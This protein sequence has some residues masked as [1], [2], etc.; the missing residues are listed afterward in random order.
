MARWKTLMSGAG[1]LAVVLCF[2]SLARADDT[3]SGAEKTATIAPVFAAPLPEGVATAR[4]TC[5]RG[6][7]VSA[8]Y[9]NSVEPQLAVI[10]VE[11]QQVV[12]QSGPTG[13][14]ARYTAGE[15]GYIWHT[16]G[17]G[18]FLA[19]NDEAGIETV[20]ATDCQQD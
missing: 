16:K 12:L 17:T 3:A 1:A 15:T 13:S 5:A 4:Y 14:G 2:G 9:I 7:S 6:A 8:A 20:L 18:A 11:G 10:V 19:W